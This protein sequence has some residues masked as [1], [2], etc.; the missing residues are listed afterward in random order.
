M[1]RQKDYVATSLSQYTEIGIIFHSSYK[2]N[3]NNAITVR[4]RYTTITRLIKIKLFLLQIMPRNDHR[5][6]K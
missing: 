5:I 4:K 1:T 2:N 3:Y 6:N